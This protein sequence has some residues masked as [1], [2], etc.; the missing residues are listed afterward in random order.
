MPCWISEDSKNASLSHP[1][2]TSK[3]KYNAT[4]N[5]SNSRTCSVALDN[6]VNHPLMR[7][8]TNHSAT[9]V[10]QTIVSMFRANRSRAFLSSDEA[11][12]CGRAPFWE[13]GDRLAW[14]DGAQC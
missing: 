5:K 6:V 1:F 10:P 11:E 12:T 3:P 13:P 9:S 7:N 2:E 14:R 8:F 4:G